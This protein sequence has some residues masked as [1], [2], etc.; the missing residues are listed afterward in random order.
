MRHTLDADYLVVGA[1]ASG[2]AFT[3]ALVDHADVQVVVVDR[4]HGPGGHWLDGYPFVRLHQASVF[5]GVASMEL[6]DGTLQTDGPEAGLHERATAP[7]ICAYYVRVMDRLQRS[8]K[9][10]FLLG[11]D[12]LGDGVVRSRVSGLDRQVRVRRRV[13][14]AHYLEPE[15]PATTP[16]PFAAESDGVIAVNRLVSLDA[17][18]P[19]YVVVGSGK[20]ATD[21]CIWLLGNGVDPDSICW[22][23]PRDPW[24]FNRAV[25]QP[26]PAVFTGMVADTVEAAEQASSLDDLFLRLEDAGVMLRIDR[27]VLPTMART[28]TLAQW[29]LDL[30][31]SIENVVRLGH[32]RSVGVDTIRLDQGE[33]RIAPGAVVV[34]CAAAGLRD[35]PAVPI[36]DTEGI[37]I[38]PIRS[39]FP[40]FGAALAGYVEATRA[41]D[42]EKNRVCPSSPYGNSLADWGRMMVLG[43]RSAVSF[44][45]EP[46]IRQWAQRC[47]LNPAR[48]APEHRERP[49]V[50]A[51]QQR[52]GEHAEAGIARL[53]ELARV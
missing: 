15:I 36:W 29:E 28:P 44:G 50:R 34:H 16:A 4:R 5:Y 17:A 23:R 45:S 3:D 48:I 37:T 30:L 13:V 7:E 51:A 53:A 46:D 26:E 40:C 27:D 33:V 35:A 21:A 10:N 8:G 2:L 43:Y 25:V 18:P 24:M 42:E 49:D 19:Q 11:C 47:L 9:V 38:Q 31:R 6:G 14:N 52:V 32:V 22:V 1:G 12:Y 20:T 41:D 39:G